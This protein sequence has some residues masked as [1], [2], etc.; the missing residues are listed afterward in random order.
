MISLAVITL[1][2][3]IAAGVAVTYWALLVPMMAGLVAMR[4]IALS[5]D[6]GFIADRR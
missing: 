4:A 5:R 2:T 3:G 1:G 6:A